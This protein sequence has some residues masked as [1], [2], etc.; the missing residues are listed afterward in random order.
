VRW[1][2]W[3]LLVCAAWGQIPANHPPAPS[4]QLWVPADWVSPAPDQWHSK[5]GLLSL[6]VAR[7]R[8]SSNR[9]EQ[10]LLEVRSKFPGQLTERG[11]P[12]PVN[13][14]PGYYLQGSYSN[15]THHLVLS[16]RGQDGFLLVCSHGP[17]QSFAAGAVLHEILSKSRWVK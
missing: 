5:D 2:L 13:G 6:Q 8:L 17:A 16:Q 1:L 3:L 12:M 14:Q 15:R 9:L 10:W 11:R 4:F 7:P